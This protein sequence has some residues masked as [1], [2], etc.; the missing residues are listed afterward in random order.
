[1]IGITSFMLWSWIGSD[2]FSLTSSS[3]FSR[4]YSASSRID[5]SQKCSCHQASAFS[6]SLMVFQPHSNVVLAFKPY[7]TPTRSDPY[8][9]ISMAS[10][11]L[12]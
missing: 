4:L 8:G 3:S 1:M 7:L 12:Q 10:Q 11:N 2:T 6:I 5:I 9:Q